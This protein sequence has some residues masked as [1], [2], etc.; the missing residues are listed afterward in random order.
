MPWYDHAMKRRIFIG[1]DLPAELKAEAANAITQWRFLPIRWTPPENW[2]ITLV[3]PRYLEDQELSALVKLL[4]RRKIDEPFPVV[5]SRVLL[6]P[7]GVPA[8]M[9][10]LE[11]ATPPELPKLKHKLEKLW[12]SQPS[13]PSLKPELRLPHLHVTLARFEP[14]HLRELEAKTRVL[15]EV[16]FSFTA[17]EIAVMESHLKP[18]GAEYET[19]ATIPLIP[20]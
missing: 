10:W 4:E 17:R 12:V 11:G 2:H 15:G 7:P 3:P 16:N 14:G 6:A 13:V 9:I 5:F 19:L 20:L 1:I 8:R 18:S